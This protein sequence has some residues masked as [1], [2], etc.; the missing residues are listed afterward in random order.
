MFAVL[1]ADSPHLNAAQG[2]WVL[3]FGRVQADLSTKV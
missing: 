2:G 3:A 1:V